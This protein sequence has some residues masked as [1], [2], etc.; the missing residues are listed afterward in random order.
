M[1]KKN[2]FF[3]KNLINIFL[4]ISFLFFSYFFAEVIFFGYFLPIMPLSNQKFLPQEL[5]PLAQ[6]SKRFS[7]PNDYILILGDS[8]AKGFGD[9]LWFSNAKKNLPYSTSH[10]IFHNLSRDVISFGES[11]FGNYNSYFIHPMITFQDINSYYLY[12]L[13]DPKT[14][15]IY[16]YE[17]NDLN[18][19]LYEIFGET[20]NLDQLNLSEIK[21]VINNKTHNTVKYTSESKKR[22]NAYPLARYLINRIKHFFVRTEPKSI[23]EFSYGKLNKIYLNFSIIE[24]PENLQSPAMEL[25]DHEISIAI[26]VFK[27]SI[28]KLVEIFPESK[29]YIAYVPSP[30]SCYDL[31]SEKV[32]IQ[33]YHGR[34]N[35][36]ES[37]KV[38]E[39]SD[40]IF[41]M[42][43][44]YS[45][46][47]NISLID[48]RPE[49]RIAAS[50][51]FIHGPIDW[52]H[53][54][55][56]GYV[57]LSEA[58]LKNIALRN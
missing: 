45:I 55:K 11:S 28:D 8:Y 2:N 48:T 5:Q 54:N 37:R 35:I 47:K 53:F 57:V 40:K 30:L 23:E 44:E 26:S 29:I 18:N 3:N 17:G 9:W 10:L 16:F 6:S 50:R 33:S 52:K 22:Y 39:Y 32:S 51:K 19:N 46:Y 34:V 36:R 20:N 49:L 58:I 42:I 27:F 41:K 4:L 43:Q 13:K 12:D 7:I 21:E 56:E 14:I 15:L 1:V 31:A 38:G 24:L 25:S